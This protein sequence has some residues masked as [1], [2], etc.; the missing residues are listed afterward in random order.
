MLAF[1]FPPPHT[2]RCT[3]TKPINDEWLFQNTQYVSESV[4]AQRQIDALI[5]HKC[6]Q[7]SKASGGSKG[8]AIHLEQWMKG[9]LGRHQ[10][11]ESPE[12]EEPELEVWTEE[13]FRKR[14]EE[15]H[16][17]DR[18]APNKNEIARAE[19]RCEEMVL[20]DQEHS[21]SRS[22]TTDSQVRLNSPNL[23]SISLLRW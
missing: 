11:P 22:T 18:K 9:E 2:I 4:E 16:V 5:E 1:Q 20:S 12:L 14:T 8:N 6:K 19:S 17:L 3:R 23:F 7:L 10:Q 15:L 21:P 13:M